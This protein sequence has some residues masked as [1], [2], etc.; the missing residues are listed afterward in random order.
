MRRRGRPGGFVWAVMSLFFGEGEVFDPDFSFF[1]AEDEA[2]A[3]P[4][5]QDD[6]ICNMYDGSGGSGKNEK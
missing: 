3:V 2:D 4:F 6:S 5:G 1:A